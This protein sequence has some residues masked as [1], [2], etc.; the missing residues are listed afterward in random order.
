M[1]DI[2]ILRTKDISE[3]DKISIS[4]AKSKLSPCPICGTPAYISKDI[5][6]GFD[7]GW[8]VGCPKFC[9]NDGIH[10][11]DENSPEDEHLSIFL[12]GSALECVTEWNKKVEYIKNKKGIN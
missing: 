10:N 9:F 11:I 12:L 4:Y 6:D 5:V 7:F 2:H 8:S 3:N 1:S